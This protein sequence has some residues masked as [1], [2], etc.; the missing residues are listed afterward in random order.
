MGV[1]VGKFG[2]IRPNGE[3]ITNGEYFKTPK[4][5]AEAQRIW[6]HKHNAKCYNKVSM[7]EA[8]N[9]DE[10]RYAW[11]DKPVEVDPLECPIS[12]G[13]TEVESNSEGHNVR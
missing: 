2:M 6:C 11:L 9:C 8:L 1:F 12:G 5:R 13:E 10:C 7:H 4:E 3:V